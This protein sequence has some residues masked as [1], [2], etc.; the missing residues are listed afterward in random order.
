LRYARPCDSRFFEATGAGP[1]AKF[2]DDDE[3]FREVLTVGRR[4]QD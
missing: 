4:L 2:I 3:N 1:E